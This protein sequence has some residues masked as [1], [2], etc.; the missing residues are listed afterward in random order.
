MLRAI[1]MAARLGF[2]IDAPIDDAIASQ[3]RRNRRSAPARLIE[4]FYK[5]L[6]S[7]ASERAF[8]MMAERRL[9]EP[10]AHELQ[11]SAGERLWQSLAALDAYRKRHNE[12]P[13]TLTNAVLLGSLLVPLG[14]TGHPRRPARHRAGTGSPAL[15]RACCRSH[16]AMSSGSVR[17]WGCSDDCWTRR[18]SPRARRALHASRPVSRG[19][20]LAR[21]PRTGAGSCRTLARLHRSVRACADRSCRGRTRRRRRSTPA[22]DGGA[23]A[24]GSIR[25]RDQL[26]TR[27]CARTRA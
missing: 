27:G 9:L 13:E 12:V 7:G 25:P 24:S 5:L 11:K 16:A 1:A 4:E 20:D 2:T 8:R 14:M 18:L 19:V 22:A 23:S 26:S 21:D 3:P 6:R 10:I 15:A 17:F